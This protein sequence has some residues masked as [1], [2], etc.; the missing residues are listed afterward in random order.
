MYCFFFFLLVSLRITVHNYHELLTF[1]FFSFLLLHR[2]L[3]QL[4]MNL[5]FNLDIIVLLVTYS[6]LLLLSQRYT[7]KIDVTTLNKI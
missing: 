2:P 7:M 4:Y 5:R 6:E 3:L 1:E